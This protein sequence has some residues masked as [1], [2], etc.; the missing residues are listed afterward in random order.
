MMNAWYLHLHQ[1]KQLTAML[2][3]TF[4]VVTTGKAFLF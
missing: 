4:K 2:F 3:S 1:L